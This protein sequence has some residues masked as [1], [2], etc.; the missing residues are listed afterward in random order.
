MASLGIADMSCWVVV[1]EGLAELAVL[2]SG[3][4]LAIVADTTADASASLIDSFVE[5]TASG[6][7]VA[8]TASTGVGL[9]AKCRFPGYVVEK[10]LTLFTVTAFGVVIALA[11][12]V[13][14]LVFVR[15]TVQWKTSGSVTVARARATNGHVLDGIVVFLADF[16]TVV[17]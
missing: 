4:V 8:V 11:L 2:A 16:R 17:K 3:V 6:M 12:T 15:H 1:E 9:F 10:V 14:H 7:L 13:N 5:V